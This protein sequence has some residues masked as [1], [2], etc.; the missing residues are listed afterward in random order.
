M[1]RGTDQRAMSPEEIT[2]S[3]ELLL[4]TARQHTCPYWLLDGR[5]HHQEQPQ[6]LQDWMQEEFFPRVR[7]ALGEPAH[8]AF[9][10]LPLV[11][12]SISARGYDELADWYVQAA[13]LAWFTDEGAARAW[14]AQ[15]QERHP[16]APLPANAVLQG[17]RR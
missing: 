10:V 17:A 16:N 6:A 1:L 9:L 15:Q 3:Y 12:A 11:W 8:V 14:L 4:A 5:H 2:E 7:E 13:H